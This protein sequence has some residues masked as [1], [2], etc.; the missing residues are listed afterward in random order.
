[1]HTTSTSHFP[2]HELLDDLPNSH[3]DVKTQ[4]GTDALEYSHSSDLQTDVDRQIAGHRLND[5]NTG[6]GTKD[7]EEPGRTHLGARVCQ[8]EH[9]VD[10][11]KKLPCGKGCL[12]WRYHLS[13]ECP[14][15][16]IDLL[17]LI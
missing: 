3:T 14:V 8:G 10:M 11:Q 7:V 17:Y 6:M 16:V 1:M 12:A 9:V 15:R 4:T 5:M 13:T 2:T